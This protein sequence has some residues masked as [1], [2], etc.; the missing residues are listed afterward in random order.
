MDESTWAGDG[1]RHE[2]DQ[3]T[4]RASQVSLQF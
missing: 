2:A 3:V 1:Q 4:D